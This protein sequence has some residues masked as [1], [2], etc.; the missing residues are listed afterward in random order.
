MNRKWIYRVAS[1]AV[2]AGGMLLLGTGTANAG[3]PVPGLDQSASSPAPRDGAPSII[4]PHHPDSRKKQLAKLLSRLPIRDA[5]FNE[6]AEGAE[7]GPLT[8]GAS[9]ANGGQLD[10]PQLTGTAR[11]AAQPVTDAVPVGG[12]LSSLVGSGSEGAE[13]AGLGLV[14][15]LDTLPAPLSTLREAQPLPFVS[16]RAIQPLPLSVP[17]QVLPVDAPNALEAGEAPSV[18]GKAPSLGRGNKLATDGLLPR[19]GIQAV[20]DRLLST[21]TQPAQAGPAPSATKGQSHDAAPPAQDPT[22]DQGLVNAV[23]DGLDIVD[24]PTDAV[25][26]Q[27]DGDQQESGL[28][29]LL[30]Q[31]PLGTG[32]AQPGADQPNGMLGMPA[33]PS[34]PN[35]GKAGKDD[36]SGHKAGNQPGDGPGNQPGID[37]PSGQQPPAQ[38]GAK[39]LG[40]LGGLLGMIGR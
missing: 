16:E 14:P 32:T 24:L 37:Q 23:T 13:D 9:P 8:P 19:G 20:F 3:S 25:T 12:P 33:M 10:L 18:G 15:Q 22:G 29:G 1:A 17:S 5:V 11:D 31:Q 36:Q 2:V 7:A 26:G 34:M 27:V 21:G 40:S 39:P 35:P 30:G 38:R 4:A 28:G 6:S